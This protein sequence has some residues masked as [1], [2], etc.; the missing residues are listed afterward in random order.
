LVENFHG[1]FIDFSDVEL[2]V[3]GAIG[4]EELLSL[5]QTV[6]ILIKLIERI[7][8]LLLLLLGCKMTSHECQG[9]L[10]KF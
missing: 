9:R 6:T 3:Q 2:R 1:A 7:A 10:L 5:N 8:K 4:F